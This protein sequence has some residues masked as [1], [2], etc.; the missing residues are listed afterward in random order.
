MGL[1]DLRLPTAEVK[2]QGGT[3]SVRGLG[4]AD[5]S[6]LFT[7]HAET[8]APLYAAHVVGEDNLTDDG[9]KGV[10]LLLIQAAPEAVA[11]MIALASDDPG[12][13]DIAR[14]LPLPVQLDAVI[15]IGGLTF[16]GEDDVKNFAE[17]AIA[18]MQRATG[19]LT[20]LQVTVA[21]TN[22]LDRSAVT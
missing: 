6:V 8:L 19:V 11:E 12:S 17:T 5:I 14:N 2:T 4:F 10:G 1:R 22:G 15:K 9:F 16:G 21:S 20:K 7:N 3:F 18:A 13:V